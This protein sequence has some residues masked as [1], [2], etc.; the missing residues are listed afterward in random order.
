MYYHDLIIEKATTA[1]GPGIVELLKSRAADLKSKGS[2]QWSFLLTGQ[3]DREILALVSKGLF[4]KAALES[5]IQNQ[6]PSA[7]FMLSNTQEEWD[8]HLWGQEYTRGTV[9]LHKLAVALDHKGE[10]LGDRL[11]D[12]IKQHAEEQGY[13]KIRLDCV[14]SAQLRSFYD[15]HGFILLKIVDDHCL[16]EWTTKR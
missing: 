1:D 5:G 4:Y 16:Y 13:T 2:M 11:V 10:G 9:Y 3:E 12:W 6:P 14:A 8:I 15:K 7:T